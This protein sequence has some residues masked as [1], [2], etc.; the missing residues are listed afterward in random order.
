MKDTISSKSVVGFIQKDGNLD[1]D[2]FLDMHNVFNL[3][4]IKPLAFCCI[5]NVLGHEYTW[6]RLWF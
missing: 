6:L 2:G 1:R 4:G 5:E 3:L